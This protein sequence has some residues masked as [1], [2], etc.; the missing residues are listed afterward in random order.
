MHASGRRVG[1]VAAA[2]SLCNHLC[3]LIIHVMHSYAAKFLCVIC[4][5]H[6]MQFLCILRRTCCYTQLCVLSSYAKLCSFALIRS[7]HYA[8]QVVL[9]YC[10]C[11]PFVMQIYVNIYLAIAKMYCY[12]YFMQSRCYA[13]LCI[14][15]YLHIN[16]HKSVGGLHKTS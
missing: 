4:F 8:S 1:R 5:M 11:V 10:L 9:M 15:A 6:V 7:P 16:M 14:H 13:Q 12:D 2:V 3:I